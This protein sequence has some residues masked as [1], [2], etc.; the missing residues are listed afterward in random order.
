MS[1]S[2]SPEMSASE[3]PLEGPKIS[4]PESPKISDSESPLEGP[5]I[6][7]PE[8][9]KNSGSESPVEVVKSSSDVSFKLSVFVVLIVVSLDKVQSALKL[10][11]SL[12][13]H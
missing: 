7:D 12:S 9:P 5:K 1:I 10:C 3:S 11:H 2:E 6:S 13:I 8:S 4:D